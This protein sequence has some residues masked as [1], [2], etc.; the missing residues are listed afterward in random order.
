MATLTDVM[1]RSQAADAEMDDFM[2]SIAVD[3]PSGSQFDETAQQ[4]QQANL[5][6][7][8]QSAMKQASEV[9]S[10]LDAAA[11]KEEENGT[12]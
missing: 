4:V 11:Q 12:P 9:L 3:A 1:Q 6:Q 5:L 10:G 8:F 2:A 7:F